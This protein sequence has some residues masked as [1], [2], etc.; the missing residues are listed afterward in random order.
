MPLRIL[1]LLPWRGAKRW[2]T[3]REL[4]LEDQHLGNAPNAML[5]MVKRGVIER[6]RR[7]DVGEYEYARIWQRVPTADEMA[8]Y[9]RKQW[10]PASVD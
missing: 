1:E 10:T 4:R 9:R 5:H 2:M 3:V 6:R 7:G 8:E